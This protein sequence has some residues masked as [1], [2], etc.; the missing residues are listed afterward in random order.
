[1][2]KLVTLLVALTI[3]FTLAACSGGKLSSTNAVSASQ[4][5]NGSGNIS[6]TA[7]NAKQNSDA[8]SSIIAVVYDS[9]DEDSKWNSSETSY[10][11]L[12]GKSITLDGDGAVIDGSKVAI[13]SAGTS[14]ISGTL[15]DGQVIVNTKDKEIVK[16]I[17][18]GANI[19]SSSSAPVYI[20]KAKKTVIV[21]ADGTD[22]YV[23]D[24][25]SYTLEDPELN[26]PNAAIFS[27]CD[28]QCEL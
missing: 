14:S 27:K 22:N 9:D 2:K 25:D 23:T 15:D 7:V 11:T 12:K 17:F 20:M 16:L 26:E 24:G 4:S 5:I 1:M 8:T 18:N 19:T 10:I 28:S 6:G 21:L 13:T 3:I